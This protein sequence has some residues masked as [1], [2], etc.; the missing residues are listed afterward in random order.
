[1][2]AGAQDCISIGLG[3]LQACPAE[4]E[5]LTE[6]F[7]L[8]STVIIT[9]EVIETI[10]DAGNE[11]NLPTTAC[12]DAVSAFVTQGCP[13]DNTLLAALPP[14]LITVEGLDGVVRVISAACG[15]PRV[16]CPDVESTTVPSSELE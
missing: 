16:D 7:A 15:T 4:Q 13:C 14:G 1:M 10:V 9:D 6:Q 8:N 5:L 3:L 2:N 12:C 11:Q